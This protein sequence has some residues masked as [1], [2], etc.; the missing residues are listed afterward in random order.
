MF[1]DNTEASTSEDTED[2][3]NKIVAL[4]SALNTV[5][6][7]KKRIETSFQNDKKRLLS[8]KE[9]VRLLFFLLLTLL[10]LIIT[11]TILIIFIFSTVVIL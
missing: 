8:E 5:S 6:S 9:K 10:I 3:K 1:Q 4:T 11:I 7:E 2:L